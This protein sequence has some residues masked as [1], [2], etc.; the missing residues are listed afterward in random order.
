VSDHESNW[1]ID[2]K[3]GSDYSN[4]SENVLLADETMVGRPESAVNEGRHF[5]DKPRGITWCMEL[6][7][8]GLV[9][10]GLKANE[11]NDSKR[12]KILRV[13][14]KIDANFQR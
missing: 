2:S 4:M 7:F 5:F 13:N 1:K 9:T 11:Y 14:Y 6:V 8:L 10:R 12:K 3:A